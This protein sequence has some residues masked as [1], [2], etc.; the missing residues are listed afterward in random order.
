M[1]G[2]KAKRIK[3]NSNGSIYVPGVEQPITDK[4]YRIDELL[5]GYDPYLELM[6]IPPENRGV[7]DTKP[8]A[9]VHRPP[10]APAYYVFF[11]DDADE[12]MLA[13]IIRADN[14]RR[15][16]LTEMEA[17]NIAKE[18]IKRAEEKEAMR[19]SH[20]MAAAVLRSPKDH[21]KIGKVDFGELR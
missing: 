16:V 15:N 19:E 18:A 10:N 17:M 7:L 2:H 14:A 20:A 1:S 3:T 9:V 4:H 12:R 13:R 8:W 5:K 6:F 21:Y 11:A